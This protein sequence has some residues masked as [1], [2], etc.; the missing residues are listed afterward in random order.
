MTSHRYT[1]APILVPLITSHTCPP[2]APLSVSSILTFHLCHL[3]LGYSDTS[4]LPSPLI[5]AF[6]SSL[7]DPCGLHFCTPILSLPCTLLTS[8]LHH[9]SFFTPLLSSIV[10]HPC[11]FMPSHLCSLCLHLHHCS[12][13]VYPCF[14][15]FGPPYH[16]QFFCFFSGLLPFSPT[17]SYVCFHAFIFSSSNS[18]WSSLF[19]LSPSFLSSHPSIVAL[20]SSLKSWDPLSSSLQFLPL[21]PCPTPHFALDLSS[22]PSPGTVWLP[23]PLS[24]SAS[25]EAQCCSQRYLERPWSFWAMRQE[26]PRWERGV[27]YMGSLVGQ[28]GEKMK[29]EGKSR[30]SWPRDTKQVGR[31]AWGRSA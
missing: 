23:L 27:R 7:L 24:L 12:T 1:M 29:E 14:P 2:V 4:K 22:L 25:L 19:R 18:P 13:S 3:P 21:L 20:L 8:C 16:L 9:L 17:S 26:G 15:I 28:R 11:I 10:L 5:T 6:V 30:R 31:R